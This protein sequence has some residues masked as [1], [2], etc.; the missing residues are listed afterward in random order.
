MKV[1]GMEELEITRADISS[2][3]IIEASAGTGKTYSLERLFVRYLV[4]KG[5]DISEILVVTFTE[6]AAIELKN[7][8]RELLRK[9]ISETDRAGQGLGRHRLLKDAFSAF[10][11]SQIYT[12]HGFCQYCIKNYPFESGAAFSSSIMD[13]SDLYREAVLDYFR[14]A[15]GKDLSD[16]YLSFRKSCGDF[17]GA[18]DFFVSLLKNPSVFGEK[19]I[20]SEEECGKTEEIINIFKEGKGELSGCLENLRQ[21]T[22]D[23][24]TLEAISKAMKLRFKGPTFDKL[25]SLLHKM[26]AS[27]SVYEFFSD[28]FLSEA[29]RLKKLTFDYIQEKGC[30]PEELDETGYSLVKSVS[31]IFDAIDIF[32]D[33][34]CANGKYLFH[35]IAGFIFIK[36]AFTEISLLAGRK[37]KSASLLDFNDLIGITRKALVQGDGISPLAAELRRKYRVVLVDEFQDTDQAQW[38]IFSTIFSTVD[39]KMVLIGDPKQSIYRFRGAD[40]EVYFRAAESLPGSVRY[41]LATCYRSLPDVV[42]GINNIFSRVFSHKAGGGHG[43]S[44]DDVKSNDKEAALAV[45]DQGI[46][47]FA[48]D[49]QAGEGSKKTVFPL[50]LNLYADEIVVLLNKGILPSSVCVLAE[51][52]SD[53]LAV[54]EILRRRNIPSVYDGDINIFSSD[55]AL[56]FIDLLYALSLPGNI[57]VIKKAVFSDLFSLSAEDIINLETSGRIDEIVMVFSGWQEKTSKGMLFAVLDKIFYE[58]NPFAYLSLDSQLIKR[59]YVVRK[60]AESGGER[61][62]VNVL[63]IAEILTVRNM[64]EKENASS[65]LRYLI[66]VVEGAE[67]SDERFVRLEMEPDCVKVMTIHKS[68]GLEFSYVFFAGGFVSSKP[69]PHRE[70]YYEYIENGERYADFSKK[71]VSRNRQFRELWEEK[72]RL[73]YVAMTRA[74]TKLYLPAARNSAAAD[75]NSFYASIVYEKLFKLLEKEGIAVSLPLDLKEGDYPDK[76]KAEEAKGIVSGAIYDLLAEFCSD[77]P[78]IKFKKIKSGDDDFA[79]VKQF[80]YESKDNDT[81]GELCALKA[82]Y[83]RRKACKG[84][85][86]YS[87]SSLAKSSGLHH[88]QESIGSEIRHLGQKGLDDED[89]DNGEEAASIQG[90]KGINGADFGN[91]MHKVLETADYKKIISFADEEEAAQDSGTL[92][93][94]VAC[95]RGFVSS[96]L[97]EK[98][99]SP[100]VRLLYRTLC[101]EINAGGRHIRIGDIPEKERRHEVEFILKVGEGELSGFGNLSGLVLEDG[102]LKGFIDMIFRVGSLYYIVDWKTNYL[103]PSSKDYGAEN[104]ETAMAENNYL[105]QKDLYMTALD[106]IIDSERK[107]HIHCP[108]QGGEELSSSLIAAPETSGKVGD[109]PQIG[110]CFYLFLRGLPP[111]GR[112]ER[113]D[114]NSGIYFAPPDQNSIDRFR[115]CF[116]RKGGEN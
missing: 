9:E 28:S 41:R 60:L 90:I 92:D 36:K 84:F 88:R 23:S 37:K 83:D 58:E 24:G 77:R 63:H 57:P 93:F 62:A 4:E 82:D 34:E 61:K 99:S 12:I 64:Q 40:L 76:M 11:D 100:A 65:L 56:I 1:S 105:L 32:A 112:G 78:Y 49:N 29:G 85:S 15:E 70:S 103:G 18:V 38:E 42:K 22:F 2:G 114:A 107:G 19:L 21:L 54:L 74:A 45:P 73:Y 53:C 67:Q 27:G 102:F 50:L 104:L 52:N 66:S 47:I 110:G 108:G 13:S 39:H 113:F 79:C 30:D 44:Y 101:C 20:P 86:V 43:I 94:A 48:I 10:S 81:P 55:E 17:T 68:K 7:R 97:A 51:S 75:L 8:I 31:G 87:Y 71:S 25:S 72:K 14:T 106:M 46:E 26:T 116:M 3:M 16:C 96:E 115:A 89:A 95:A 35:Q 5:F 33:H 91:I 6:K 98:C 111:C 80:V 59:P 69:Q 109:H